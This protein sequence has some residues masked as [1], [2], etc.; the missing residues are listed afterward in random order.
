MIIGLL[1]PASNPNY[2]SANLLLGGVVGAGASQALQQMCGLKTAYM[3]KTAPRAIYYSQMIGSFAGTLI[4][5]LVYKIYTSVKKIPSEEF[6]IPD[7]HMWLVAA[8]LIYQRGLPPRALDF[9]VGAFV[10]G[11]AF[12]I[13]RILG[14]NRWWRDLVPSSVAMAIGKKRTLIPAADQRRISSKLTGLPRH[15]HC[16]CYNTASRSRQLDLGYWPRSTWHKELC[17]HVFCNGT[18]PW[19]GDI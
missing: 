12:S 18:Y 9:T 19:A 17:S 10:I 2:I 3:T 14:S 11:A 6:G 15:V 4:A 8:R 7:A 13:L 5:T 1:V 16:S